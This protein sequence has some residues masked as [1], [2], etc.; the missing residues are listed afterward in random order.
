[1]WQRFRRAVRS[2]VGFFISSVEGKQA[3]KPAVSHYITSKHALN[4]FTKAVRYRGTT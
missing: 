2:F 1:M 3:N 4:G